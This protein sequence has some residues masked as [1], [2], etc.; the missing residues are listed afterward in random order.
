MH[1]ELEAD[2]DAMSS[3]SESEVQAIMDVQERKKQEETR[4]F[5]EYRR[6]LKGEE[7]LQFRRG[8]FLSLPPPVQ[9]PAATLPHATAPPPWQ[10]STSSQMDRLRVPSLRICATQVRVGVL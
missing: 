10:S 7:E 9:P 2:M 6:S 3:M 1:D 8:S 4:K 5:L